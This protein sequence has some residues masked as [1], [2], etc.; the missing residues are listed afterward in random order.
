MLDD[1]VG[2]NEALVLADDSY[3]STPVGPD[4]RSTSRRPNRP[5]KIGVI[6]AEFPPSHGGMQ[7]HARGLVGCL[8]VDHQVFVFTGRDHDPRL[9]DGTATMRPVMQWQLAHDIPELERAPMDAWITLNAGL[10]PY[11]RRL[12]APLFAYVHG[13]DFIQPWLPHPG[14]PVRLARHVLGEGLVRKWRRHEIGAGLR[15]ARWVF[16]NSEFSR[17]V[18]AGLYGLS[19]DRFSVVPPGVRPEFFQTSS[20]ASDTRLR[21]VT[22]SRL[23]ANA[24]RK[25]IDGVIEAIACLKGEID[26]SY[27]VIGDGDDLARLRN[28]ASELGVA[29]H[30]RFLGAVDTGRLIEQFA[31][32]DAFIMAVKPSKT[33]VEGFGMV[34]AE[35]AASGLPSIGARIGGV[36]EVIEDGVTGLLLEDVSAAGIAEG[37]RH[38]NRRRASFDRNVIRMKAERFSAPSCTATIAGIITSMI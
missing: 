21:L 38:F 28:L 23:A 15:A 13:K 17:G 26:I 34:Y 7:E 20:S 4:G 31:C 9:S 14:R 5:L 3:R 2:P 29:A 35:A 36:P 30:V 33:D 19:G 11:S 1:V 10:A 12:A 8:S 18:C 6:A 32:S 22:I 24:G 25:N 16:A 27:T 37:L